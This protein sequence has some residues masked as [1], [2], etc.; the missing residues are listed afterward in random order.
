VVVLTLLVAAMPLPAAASARSPST[1]TLFVGTG[2]A[3]WR[4]GDEQGVTVIVTNH[5]TA[6]TG[7]VIRIGSPAALP[8]DLPGIFPPSG[9]KVVERTSHSFAVQIAS[10]GIG[11]KH[12]GVLFAQ[13]KVHA[14]PGQR[15]CVTA[16]VTPVRGSSIARKLC[17]P[18]RSLS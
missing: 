8:L 5:G 16:S 13:V 10:L 15:L 6:P 1:F 2:G 3:V 12:A 11:R 4:Q 18:V 17:L 14:H 9:G 7:V